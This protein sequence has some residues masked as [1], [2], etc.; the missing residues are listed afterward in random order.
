MI[1][2][3]TDYKTEKVDYRSIFTLKGLNINNPG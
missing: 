1:D 3:M 2:S